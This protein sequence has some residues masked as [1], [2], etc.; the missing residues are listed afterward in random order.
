MIAILAVAASAALTMT[1]EE[2]SFVTW[3]RM[4][5][6]VYT[7]QEYHFRFGVYLTN[8]RH[9]REHNA[10]SRFRLGMN[11]FACH[12]PAEYRAILGVRQRISTSRPASGAKAPKVS[13]YDWRDYGVVNPIKDQGDCGACWAF[14]A[15]QS[16]E[17]VYAI[18]TQ[19]PLLSFSESNLI[20]CVTTCYGCNGGL[21]TQ[22]WD[23]V[24]AYQN[25]HFN[26]EDTYPYK[27]VTSSC[28]F[29]ASAAIGLITAYTQVAPA[30]E[31][32]LAA[33]IVGYGPIAGAVDSS[34]VS[35]QLYEGGVYDDPACS[36]IN[37]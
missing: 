15:T 12:S 23:Y 33:K 28:K 32:D 9:L 37:L 26:S 3:M 27:P 4:T 18:V 13:S 14:A 20:D 19:T 10:R 31:D 17:S 30:D 24:I 5:N 22:A 21:A 29:D 25:G 6:Q 8:L 7:G 2:K 34:P 16:A 1:H 36:S 35:F 11:R